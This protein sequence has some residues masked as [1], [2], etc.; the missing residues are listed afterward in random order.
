MKATIFYLLL[1]L[2]SDKVEFSGMA[3]LGALLFDAIF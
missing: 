2:F 3:L 1:C